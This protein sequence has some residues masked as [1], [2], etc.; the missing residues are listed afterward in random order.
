MP[1]S[2][3]K[4]FPEMQENYTLRLVHG[5]DLILVGLMQRRSRFGPI[6]LVGS[7]P[8]PG[9]RLASQGSCALASVRASQR[10]SLHR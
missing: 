1:L 8:L 3:S 7:N 4:Y 10:H 9:S 2:A 5:F 6:A